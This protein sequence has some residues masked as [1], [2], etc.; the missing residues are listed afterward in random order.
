[1]ITKTKKR[2]AL[3]KRHKVEEEWDSTAA[4][5]MGVETVQ[6]VK[7]KMETLVEDLMWTQKN[8][9]WWRNVYDSLDDRF[10]IT[11]ENIKFILT[12]SISNL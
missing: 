4:V 5:F 9:K 12:I 10:H 11:R 3:K 1:M 6:N 2:K 7:K 8:W